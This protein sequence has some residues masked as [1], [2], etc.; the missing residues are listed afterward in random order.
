MNTFTEEP[1][2]TKVW[3][4]EFNLWLN[5]EDGRSISI[6]LIFFPRLKNATKEQ[7]DDFEF[8]GGGLGIHW[9]NLDEDIYVPGLLFGKFDRGIISP[10]GSDLK[11]A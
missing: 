8:S 2:A 9:E 6:P 10:L 3:F 11:S 5:L 7:L 1:K 4:D